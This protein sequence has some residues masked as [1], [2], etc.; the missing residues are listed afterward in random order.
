MR[1][2]CAWCEHEGK[3]AEL[4]VRAPL[5]DPT[6]THGM[7]PAHYVVLVREDTDVLRHLRTLQLYFSQLEEQ[8]PH[9]QTATGAPSPPALRARLIMVRRAVEAVRGW[10]PPRS[11]EER[12]AVQ[13]TVVIA[14][15]AYTRTI[16]L[17]LEWARLRL[18]RAQHTI[19]R[20]RRVL[21]ARR[22]AHGRAAATSLESD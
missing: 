9:L 3:P 7:C 2:I 5:E 4:G 16:H 17:T 8:V 14:V 21:Q 6:P 19:A 15:R 10:P 18:Q 13:R 11:R 22:Q 12:L 1:I 20:G